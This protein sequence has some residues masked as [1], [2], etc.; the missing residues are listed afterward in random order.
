MNCEITFATAAR[1]SFR[2]IMTI[3]RRCRKKMESKHFFCVKNQ[4]NN[5]D[6]ILLAILPPVFGHSVCEY[7]KGKVYMYIFMVI[8][9][10]WPCLIFTGCNYC[11][12]LRIDRRSPLLCVFFLEFKMDHKHV[13]RNRCDTQTRNIT[14]NSWICVLC[15]S[16]PV[17]LVETNED[18]S[19][20]S[21]QGNLI[22]SKA[23]RVTSSSRASGVK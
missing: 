17:S 14:T 6:K 8:R 13:C 3:L 1:K 19:R 9:E 20:S 7:M 16:V 18:S 22:V 10:L 12:T 21:S 11:S 5:D 2:S 4:N 15:V 23:P